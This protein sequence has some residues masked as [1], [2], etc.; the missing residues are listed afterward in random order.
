MKI[1]YGITKSNF[2]G[3]Q[4]YVYELA[5]ESKHRGFDT[6]VILGGKGILTEKLESRGVR[7]LSLNS[8]TRDIRLTDDLRS[9]V[10]IYKIL[11]KE[12]PDVFHINSSKMGGMGTLAA[13]LAGVDKIIFTG[14]AWAFNEPRPEWQKNIIKTFAWLTIMLSHTTI[15]VSEKTKSDIA[16]WP[17]VK[18]RLAVVHNG[19]RSG[20]LVSREEARQKLGIHEDTFAVGTIS[21]LHLIKGLDILLRAWYDFTKSNP[22]LLVIIGEGEE[23]VN[24]KKLA[25]KLGIEK[26][27]YFAGFID[28]ARALLSAFDVFVLA[29]RSEALPYAP[30][31]AG[32]ASLPVIATAVGGVPEIIIDGETGVLIEPEFPEE[33]CNVLQGLAADPDLRKTL[34]E[35]LKKFVE[36]EYSLSQM[37]DR[38]FAL[39]K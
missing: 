5:R 32:A 3:A 22:G 14:H 18:N 23:R 21:E 17:F 33:L 37:F 10:D 13:R 29:S 36:K 4:R 24:L 2:G 25:Q 27:V 31:E 6:A 38:T 12:R 28:N 15:C 26:T 20:E 30:L 11:R 7:V 1:L 19:S 16:K 9:F 34:G 39:Y 35:N 8:L